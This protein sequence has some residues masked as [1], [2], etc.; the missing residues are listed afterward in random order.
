MWVLLH[1]KMFRHWSYNMMS[2]NPAQQFQQQ[3]SVHIIWPNSRIVIDQINA[4]WTMAYEMGT[5]FSF[6]PITVCTC[7]LMHFYRWWHKLTCCRSSVSLAEG[8]I[9][10]NLS[11]SQ[12]CCLLTPHLHAFWNIIYS[13]FMPLINLRFKMNEAIL[14]KQ[15]KP[16]LLYLCT[17]QTFTTMPYHIPNYVDIIFIFPAWSFSSSTTLCKQLVVLFCTIT[18]EIPLTS[19]HLLEM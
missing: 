12:L 15:S 8:Y 13:V 9:L 16:L 3:C 2:R 17:C 4:A 5:S 1:D 6:L 7:N 10:P 11:P 18:E 19:F 14:C